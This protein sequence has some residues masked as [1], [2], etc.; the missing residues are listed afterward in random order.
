[1]LLLLKYKYDIEELDL[2]KLI[3]YL[4]SLLVLLYFSKTLFFM[5]CI[6]DVYVYSILTNVNIKIDNNKKPKSNLKMEIVAEGVTKTETDNLLNTL[7]EYSEKF[8][9]NDNNDLTNK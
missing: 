3:I 1:M 2:N 6:I 9:S 5:I 7:I 4:V 8:N